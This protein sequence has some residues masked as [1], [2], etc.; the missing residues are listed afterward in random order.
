[1]LKIGRTEFI[2]AAKWDLNDLQTG[3]EAKNANL[4]SESQGDICRKLEL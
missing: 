3:C 2:T 1:L 4:C